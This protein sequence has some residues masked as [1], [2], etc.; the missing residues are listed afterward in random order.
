M[1]REVDGFKDDVKTARDAGVDDRQRDGDPLFTLQHLDMRDRSLITVRGE[2]PSYAPTPRHE[3]P[4]INY[5]EMGNPLLTVQHLDTRDRS[6]ITV[7]W[8]IPFLQSNT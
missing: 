6:L 1:S 8:G 4:V 2:S 3:G 5:S 7:R